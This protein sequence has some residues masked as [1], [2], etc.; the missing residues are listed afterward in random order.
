[1]LRLHDH[2]IQ[3]DTII[4]RSTEVEPLRGTEPK[5]TQAGI[6]TL[7]AATRVVAAAM[8]T[9]RAREMEAAATMAVTRVMMVVRTRGTAPVV[10]HRL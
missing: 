4:K 9:E 6:G 3:I 10:S 8:A 5:G 7:V 2:R 1:M